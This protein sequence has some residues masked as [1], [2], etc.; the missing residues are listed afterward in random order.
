MSFLFPARSGSALTHLH[1]FGFSVLLRVWQTLMTAQ[2]AY[3]S[4]P[5]TLALERAEWSAPSLGRLTP[6]KRLC[7][8]CTGG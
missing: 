3:S 4:T 5:F 6:G 2:V 8:L 1:V 7:T